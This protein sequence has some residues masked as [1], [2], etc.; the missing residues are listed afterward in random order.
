MQWRG[1]SLNDYELS[2]MTPATLLGAILGMIGN[3]SKK[4]AGGTNNPWASQGINTI[5]GHGR[6]TTVREDT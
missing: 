6:A 2:Q 4:E 3:D 1:Y 5:N